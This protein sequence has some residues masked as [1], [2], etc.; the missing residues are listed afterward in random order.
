MMLKNVED[1]KRFYDGVL[2]PD[3]TSLENDRIKISKRLTL[4]GVGIA[5]VFIILAILYHTVDT[6]NDG[7]FY[8]YS[9]FGC[10][11]LW[12]FILKILTKNY[13]SDFKSKIIHRIIEFINPSL[14]YEKHDYILQ[15][16]FIKCDIFKR[17]PD[18]YNGDD[19]VTG[20]LGA[21]QVEFSEIHAE[22]V[23][24]NSK[25]HTQYHTI[26]KGLFFVAD[27]NKNFAGKTLIL[28]DTAERLF[29][30]FGSILQTWN[31]GR[32]ELVRLE[33]PE[34]EKF[35]VVYGD[36]QVEARYILS[37]SLMKRIVDFK[38]KS[39]KPI[40]VSFIGSKIFIAISYSK[41]LFEPRVFK[42]LLD[43]NPI[44]EY[45]EDLQLAIGIV[46]DLNLNV[47]IWNK[48]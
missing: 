32:G 28:P 35:F 9:F 25:G 22:Y 40:Y 4:I 39:K 19:Y 16:N 46:D 8:F 12:M 14:K 10:V 36:D 33:D 18:Q 6:G 2:V 27:F 34:F 38:K 21:T 31:K 11:A 43:F 13:V 48:Q 29:G 24:R 37:T 30:Q 1:L 5:I 20:L 3:L 7:R 44:R 45:Y 23:T 17:K 47:R 15:H 41:N 42:T 26:F